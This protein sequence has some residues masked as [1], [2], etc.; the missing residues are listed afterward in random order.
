MVVARRS[1][2]ARDA[3]RFRQHPLHEE[4]AGHELGAQI[5]R[6]AVG[7]PAIL[8]CATFRHPRPHIA[9]RDQAEQMHVVGGG[10]AGIVGLRHRV[11]HQPHGGLL[12]MAERLESGAT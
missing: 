9:E 4:A 2:C 10:G 12:Q 5:G 6:R 7:P 11:L 1:G 8:S 3:R